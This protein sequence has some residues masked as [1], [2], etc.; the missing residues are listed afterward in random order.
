[1]DENR[2][3]GVMS[4]V[5]YGPDAGTWH[6]TAPALTYGAS[7][8]VDAPDFRDLRRPGETLRVFDAIDGCGEC[9]CVID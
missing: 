5:V 3:D 6:G 7:S 2:Q 1:M 8:S 9:E 4:F